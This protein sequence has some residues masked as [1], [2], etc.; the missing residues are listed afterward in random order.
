[1]SGLLSIMWF[2]IGIVWVIAGKTFIEVCACFL[3]CGIFSGA[4]E[5]YLM[6]KELEDF[7]EDE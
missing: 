4:Y 3:L 1:M 7:E 5:L 6:R 2:I